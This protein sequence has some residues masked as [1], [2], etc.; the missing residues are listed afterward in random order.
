MNFNV[1]KTKKITDD[2]VEIDVAI[3]D[4]TVISKSVSAANFQV[5]DIKKFRPVKKYNED[6]LFIPNKQVKHYEE[7]ISFKKNLL[8]VPSNIPKFINEHKSSVVGKKVSN[9]PK[10]NDK[11]LSKNNGQSLYKHLLTN[12]LKSV[13]A[14]IDKHRNYPI[15]ARKTGV[16]GVTLL[17]FVLNKN[18]KV[19]NV[20][21]LK[22]SGFK[23]LDK[24]AV[25]AVKSSEPF[26]E[27]PKKLHKN[28]LK[29]RLNMVFKLD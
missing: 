20:K 14:I 23:I 9:A 7:N 8:T 10:Q 15:L 16:E 19:S 13:R 25:R 3:K 2:S 28:V 5:P 4:D 18:G 24:S 12:Y 26:P 27:I 1:D 11:L 17:M 29:I 22:T 21:I 6:S